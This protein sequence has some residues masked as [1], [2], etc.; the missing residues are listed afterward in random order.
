[1]LKQ[2]L[3]IMPIA[4]G[5]D[6]NTGSIEIPGLI[7]RNWILEVLIYNLTKILYVIQNK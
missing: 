4:T 6:F 1:M 2:E 5:D 7:K 3:F